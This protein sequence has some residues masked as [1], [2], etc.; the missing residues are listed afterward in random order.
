MDAVTRQQPRP[1][2]TL[3]NLVVIGAAKCATTSLH[4]YLDQH[5]DISM[6][7]VKELN[8]FRDPDWYDKVEWYQRQF[9]PSAR[10][11]GESSPLYTL[12]PHERGTAARM[13]YLIPD[14]KLIY[15]VRDPIERTVAYWAELYSKHEESRSIEEAL[16]RY[17]H[18]ENKFVCPSKYALQVEEYLRHFPRS[19]LLVVDQDDLRRDLR[20]TLGEIF[21]FLEVD[22]EFD[23]AAFDVRLNATAGKTR[24]SPGYRHFQ[25]M[26]ARMGVMHIPAAVRG[27]AAHAMRARFSTPVARPQL[28]AGL[29][30]GLAEVLK[31]DA[32]RLREITGKDFA[33]WSV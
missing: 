29:R 31:P 4:H 12:Y 33:G 13:A 19:S 20:A 1:A 10:V 25:H 14:A 26:A 23:T 16:G 18:P 7:Q 8:Y 30:A 6:S 22:A 28:D 3:P 5:P 17:D 21:T 27:P 11:R 15:L 9:D 2:T 32:D 24:V